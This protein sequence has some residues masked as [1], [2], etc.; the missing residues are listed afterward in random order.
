MKNKINAVRES[1]AAAPQTTKALLAFAFFAVFFLL[2][3]VF[4]VILEFKPGISDFSKHILSNG[5]LYDLNASSRVSLYYGIFIATAA[6]T[7]GLFAL[8]HR[9]F[10]S[11][12]ES[13]EKDNRLAEV[14]TLS[15]IGVV[16]LFAG[17][18]LVNAQMAVFVI[19]MLCVFQLAAAAKNKSIHY[20]DTLYWIVGMALVLSVLFFELLDKWGSGSLNKPITIKQTVI[21]LNGQE[22]FFDLIFLLVGVML[23]FFADYFFR[24]ASDEA[25]LKARQSRLFVA[26]IPAVSMVLLQSILLEFFNILNVRYGYVFDKPRTLFVIVALLTIALGFALYARRQNPSLSPAAVLSKYHF[27]ILIVSL[28]AMFVQ[29]DRL[30][31][32]PNEFFEFAN[33]GLSV[34]HFF[35]YGSIPIVDTFDA[36]MLSKQMFAYLYGFLNGYEPFA[37]FLYATFD[38]MAM[39]VLVYLLLCKLTG[40]RVAF[41]LAALFPMMDAFANVYILSG[42][43]ALQLASVEQ[44]R[45]LKWYYFFWGSTALLLFYTLDL[46]FA[47]FVSGIFT[48]FVSAWVFKRPL[49]IK[50]FVTT[51]LITYGGLLLLF[52][53][54]CL[55]KS[56]NPIER[57]QQFLTVAASNQNFVVKEMGDTSTF[58][59][60][61]AY[62]GLPIFMIAAMV[63]LAI[64]SGFD[65]AFAQKLQTD[66]VRQAAFILFVF[67]SAFFFFNIPRGIIRH[68]LAFNVIFNI[69]ST[70]PIAIFCLV[71]VFGKARNFLLTLLVIVAGYCF[72]NFNQPTFKNGNTNSSLFTNAV[73]STGFKEKFVPAFDFKGTRVVPPADMPDAQYL[74]SMLDAILTPQETYFDFSCNNYYHALTGRKNPIYENQSI[75][76]NGDDAQDR[77]LETLKKKGVTVVL[78]P[79]GNNFW[80]A[81]DGVFVDYKYFKIS[82]YVYENF[83]PFAEIKLATVYIRKNKLAEYTKRIQVKSSIGDLTV[84]DFTTMKPES[85][86]SNNLSI[87]NNGAAGLVLTP[88]GS[89]PFLFNF[90]Q[91][92]K[93]LEQFDQ[94][95]PVAITINYEVTAA[96]SLQLF[97]VLD[98]QEGYAEE[99]SKTVPVQP[100]SGAYVLNLPSFPKNLRIDCDVAQMTLKQLRFQ[101]QAQEETLALAPEVPNYNLIA[102]PRVWGEHADGELFG[103]VKPLAEKTKIA[104]GTVIV[105][106][107]DRIRKP[108]Y[109]CLSFVADDVHQ[110][111]V[112]LIN[113]KNQVRGEY[114]MTTVKGAQQQVIRLSTNFYWW[115]EPIS[116]V[117]VVA[118]KAVLFDKFALIAADGSFQRSFN[119]SEL[120]LSGIT[121]ANW[122][123]GVG[124]SQNAVIMDKSDKALGLLKGATKLVLEDGSEMHIAKYYET[125]NFITIEIV[126]PVAAF[127]EKAACPHTIKIVK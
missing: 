50:R 115:N 23:W 64:K 9:Q 38:Y 56:I 94:T 119:G 71:Y 66:K 79:K 100:G 29:P 11:R 117:A 107:S 47:A 88:T 61:I 31:V 105:R 33:H 19:L 14:Y 116:A 17:F 43:L 52:A 2:A 84:T 125:G 68:T 112:S 73:T 4:N 44:E 57:L 77:T 62:Y 55:A 16:A 35:R 93:P 110:I 37:P 104:S 91:Q 95:K 45:Q 89:D 76:I 118:D 108:M 3:P 53:I 72:T 121:D 22:L 42:L 80:R 46:G 82:E 87:A 58:L 27:P 123:G 101:S 26:S 70:I 63:M 111:K 28:A 113:N 90:L 12:L 54:L 13:W 36:H 40:A 97:Y 5:A 99:N 34:D 75:L 6:L 120:T 51:G 102:I 127:K 106:A 41:L 86:G 85:L 69:T 92:I 59:F 32:A 78:M 48:Y 18:L 109:L 1:Y 20:T 74:K 21:A 122:F 24:N 83:T 7:A 67:F 114:Y 96:G 98:G 10:S 124:L 30:M 126:E 65:R 81:I 60:R 8:L 25:P 49:A 103:K 15:I 39:M